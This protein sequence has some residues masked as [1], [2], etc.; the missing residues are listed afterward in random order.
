MTQVWQE[1]LDYFKEMIREDITKGLYYGASVRVGRGGELVFNETIGHSDAAGEKPISQDAVFSIFSMTKAFTNILTL[2]AIEMGRFA[3]TT[4]VSEIIPEFAGP[5]RDQATFFHLLTHTAGWPGLW[6][7]RPG[8]L[9]DQLDEVIADICSYVSGMTE[10]GQRCNYQPLVNHALMGEAIRRT[11]PKKRSLRDI[12]RED[13]FE[14]LKMHNTAMG[15]RQDLQPRHI[16]PDMRGTLP[17]T[18]PGHTNKGDYG[19]FE[20]EFAEMPHVGCVATADDM[21]RFAEM[22][23]R[24]GELD[25][26]R[27][28][29]PRTIELATQCWTGDMENEL[30]RW[31]ALSMGWK[32]YP[33]YLGLGFSLK[34]RTLNYSQYGTL[35]SEGTFGNNGAG[36]SIY[37]VD[38]VADVTFVCLTAG[39]MHEGHNILRFQRYS[40]AVASAML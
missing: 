37:W 28:V 12:Y 4:K 26:A 39:V 31:L 14:P 6:E 16:I 21:W 7:V 33:A 3:L 27:I 8:A 9:Q 15:V 25:G 10:P 23:R 34:G 13:L 19:I 36:S 2:R 11:D 40:D 17:I 20:E 22:L 35:T 29:A 38:P 5:P 30:Y 1:R 32:A 18:S 24:G